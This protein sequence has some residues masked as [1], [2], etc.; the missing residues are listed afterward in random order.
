MLPK[1]TEED[2][3]NF[4]VGA[5]RA[6]TVA[7]AIFGW[8]AVVGYVPVFI[9]NVALNIGMEEE[10]AVKWATVALVMSVA[11]ATSFLGFLFAHMW[12]RRP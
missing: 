4:M 10:L 1:M 11:I 12:D 9:K 3:L 6:A 5:T 7:M 2:K 8:F